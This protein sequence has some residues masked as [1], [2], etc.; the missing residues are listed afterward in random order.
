MRESIVLS[1]KYLKL[2]QIKYAKLSYHA[3]DTQLYSNPLNIQI[4]EYFF[5]QIRFIEN[6]LTFVPHDLKLLRLEHNSI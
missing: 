5:N 2:V 1:W 6:T 3:K 4:K